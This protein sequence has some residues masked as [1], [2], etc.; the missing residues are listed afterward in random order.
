[1][2]EELVE[3]LI[4]NNLKITTAES[5]TGG[6]ISSTIISVSGASSVIDEA[7]VTY[8]NKAKEKL[9]KVRKKTILKYGVVSEEVARQMAIGALKKASCDVAIAT[10]GIAGPTGGTDKKPV[11]M[12]C[13]GFAYKN[14]CKCETK[15]FGN[16]GRNKVREESM[17]FAISYMIDLIKEEV[18]N[19]D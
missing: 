14:T 18:E 10:S 6:L 2:E 13:F 16:I 12:V 1:M 8:A 17:K 5:C 7:Y 4:K 9:L 19:N 15:Y 11:G 3:L